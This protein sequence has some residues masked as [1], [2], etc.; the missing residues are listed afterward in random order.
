MDSLYILGRR[1][2]NHWAI[3]E[4]LN[5]ITCWHWHTYLIV[6]FPE[7]AF[8]VGMSA[9]TCPQ[10]HHESS[11]LFLAFS[12]PFSHSEPEIHTRKSNLRPRGA[13]WPARN[14]TGGRAWDSSPVLLGFQPSTSGSKSLHCFPFTTPDGH[15]RVPDNMVEKDKFGF[16]KTEWQKRRLKQQNLWLGFCLVFV[17]LF[18]F[19]TCL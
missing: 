15:V 18:I 7:T 3:W 13:E 8:F 4:V 2:L 14:A 16:L 11:S 19:Q 10:P 6:Y 17:G 12:S 9:N 5:L 1:I